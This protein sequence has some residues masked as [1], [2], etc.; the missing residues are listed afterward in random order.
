M[1]ENFRAPSRLVLTAMVAVFLGACPASASET[2]EGR[3]VSAD[4]VEIGYSTRGA[5]NT[6]LVFIHGGL[7][8]RSFW[9]PQ[10]SSLS[11]TFQ[12]VALDLAGHG[13]SG[14]GRKRWVIPAFAQD[15][16]A[17]V[18]ALGSSRV[19][20]IGNSLGGAVA[21]EAAPL[22]PGRVL[23][24]VGVD[25]LQDATVRRDP[26]EAR[27]RAEAFRNDFTGT[28]LAMVGS[29]FHPQT[30]GELRAWAERR[31]CATSPEVVAAMMEGFA[32]YDLAKAFRSAGVPIRAINGDLWPTNLDGNRTITSDFDAV[33]MSGAGHYP[34]LER[35]EEFNRLLV[36]IVT[37]LQSRE[38]ADH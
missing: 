6:V 20:L 23:G 35:P 13:A 5:G 24:V 8:D 9:A 1:S 37:R 27:A 31:M 32:G 7:A 11:E 4:G 3:V 36:E 14:R 38:S 10:L 19:V 21:L 26:G 12:V 2:V 34:M 18:E 29:L 16:L 22:L 28:C 25:T 30:Q 33:I 17:V 15:V